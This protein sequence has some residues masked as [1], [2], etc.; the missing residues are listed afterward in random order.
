MSDGFFIHFPV[1]ID[2][3]PV[4][5]GGDGGGGQALAD[6]LGD[7]ARPG[8]GG[9]FADRTVGE[10]EFQHGEAPAVPGESAPPLPLGVPP[11]GGYLDRSVY[12]E[13]QSTKGEQEERG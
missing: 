2:D 9:D 6:G 10:L 13:V 4:H 7:L 3:L 8:A 12:G 5:L 1:E 11:S